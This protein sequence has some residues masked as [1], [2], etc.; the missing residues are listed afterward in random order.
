M[1][2]RRTAG[3]PARTLVDRAQTIVWI[4]SALVAARTKSVAEFHNA[5]VQYVPLPG[6]SVLYKYA[7]GDAGPSEEVIEAIAD[8]VPVTRRVFHHPLWALARPHDVS[9]AFL[10]N[11]LAALP[12]R[13][14]S[15][16][17]RSDRDGH[18]W[19]D[20][21]VSLS[22]LAPLVVKDCSLDAAA[23]VLAMVDD[24][25]L[26]QD[27][28]DHFLAWRAWARLAESS[29]GT[30]SLL[31]PAFFCKLLSQVRD[32]RYLASKPRL[33]LQKVLG[34]VKRAAILE[35]RRSS[36]SRRIVLRTRKMSSKDLLGQAL[37][38]EAILLEAMAGN[39]DRAEVRLAGYSR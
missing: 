7:R 35:V 30:L 29:G 28:G 20:P 21:E 37:F 2:S 39:Y 4:N 19:R 26:R 23:L 1:A 24:A 22:R 14:T 33:Q 3:R 6:L 31:Y 5:L 13:F 25:L 16:W 9:G 10:S 15:G 8:A 17:L 12:A 27:E 36:G 18:F 32:A 11:Q 34:Y 38:S